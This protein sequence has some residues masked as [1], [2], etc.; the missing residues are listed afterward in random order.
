[1]EKSEKSNSKKYKILVFVALVLALVTEFIL[2]QSKTF[3]QFAIG[4]VAIL[5]GIF[6]FIGMHFV[7]G[8]KKLYNYIIDNRYKL[9]IVLIIVST[10]V[11]F[12][13]NSI[14]IK[15]WLLATN[16]P[17]CLWWNIKFYAI[18]LASYELMLVITNNRNMA[19]VGSVVISCSGAIQWNFEYIT[20]IIIGEA[21]VALLSKIIKDEDPNNNKKIL[22]SCMTI[23]L[24]FA[25][26]QTTSSFAIT[27]SYIWIALVIWILIK[28]RK[29]KNFILCLGTTIGSLISA[30]VSLKYVDFGYRLDSVE[31][32]KS[33][34]YLFTYLYNILLPYM[35]I[36][37]KYL[38]GN[39][40]SLFPI[41]MLVALY[42]LY[43]HENHTEFL[44]PVTIVTVL[45][46]IFCIS[47]FPKVISQTL[48][49]EGI[50]VVRCSVAVNY[51]NLL[52][53]FYII[54]NID[55]IFKLKTAIKLTL[56]SACMLAFINY[57]VE[58]SKIKFLYLF[59]A[60]LCTLCILFY[61]YSNKKYTRMLLFT[62]T[63]LTLASGVLVNPIVKDKA[64]TVLAPTVIEEIN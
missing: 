21:I 55:E 61:N 46:T 3:S 31:N 40:I 50:S 22:M 25:Y 14:G 12:L 48:G 26:M 54:S 27:F 13:Q 1:M 2:V 16:M 17:L 58:I 42:Y 9:S 5:F 20:P 24:S 28:N 43:K 38:F 11:G 32:T 10:I 53:I 47:G 19:A 64:D 56:A 37:K 36:E 57:P 30:I 51:A 8:F 33:A 63:L 4:N 7:V 35:D 49:F 39:F 23:L 59:S 52:L 41:P 18:I 29:S 44:L 60:E 45:E 6:A 34:S 15:E 62:L